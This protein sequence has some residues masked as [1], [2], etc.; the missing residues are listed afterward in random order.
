MNSEAEKV[1]LEYLEKSKQLKVVE[2]SE[3]VA[4][5]KQSLSSTSLE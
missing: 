1:P 4:E 5:S 3:G 2:G